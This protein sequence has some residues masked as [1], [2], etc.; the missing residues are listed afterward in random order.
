MSLSWP[1]GMFFIILNMVDIEN[2]NGRYKIFIKFWQFCNNIFLTP[3]IWKLG[4]VLVLFVFT[5]LNIYKGNLAFSFMIT[6]LSFEFW[7]IIIFYTDDRFWLSKAFSLIF[8]IWYF[9][10]LNVDCI[11][12]KDTL[13]R[14]GGS[15]QGRIWLVFEAKQQD[16]CVLVVE[17][18]YYKILIIT[19][20]PEVST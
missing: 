5:I 18:F 9:V 2:Y 6:N 20:C 13:I 14:V 8:I 17:S 1:L 7:I 4:V 15:F 19:T 16:K 12:D 11:F 3:C 10:V